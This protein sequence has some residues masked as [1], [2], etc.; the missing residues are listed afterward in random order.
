MNSPIELCPFQPSHLRRILEIERAAFGEEA[1]TREMFLELAEDCPGLFFIARYARRI[2]GY[3][4]TCIGPAKAEVIS[5]AVDP[6]CHRQG[7]GKALMAR[8]LYVLRRRKVKRV[9]LMVR[10]TSQGA[11]TFY[12]NFGFTRIRRVPNYYADGAEAIHMKK[13]L[14]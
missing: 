6:R 11:I 8:T 3:M 10:S 4:V 7:V 13:L 5:I 12:H 2:A 14:E 9:D 1:Y